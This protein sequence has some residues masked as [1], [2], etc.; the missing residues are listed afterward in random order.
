MINV[1][2]QKPDKELKDHELTCIIPIPLN[3]TS[4]FIG[5]INRNYT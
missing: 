1:L 4:G 2:L 3:E 5:K